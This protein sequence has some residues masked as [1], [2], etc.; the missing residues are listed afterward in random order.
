MDAKEKIVTIAKSLISNYISQTYSDKD[1][2]HEEL[3]RIND[4]FENLDISFKTIQPGMPT[5]AINHGKGKVSLYFDDKDNV[6][7]AELINS[8][9]ILIHEVY[10]S[11]SD[12][13]NL[14]QVVFLEEGYVTLITAET[15]RYAIDNPPQI[16]GVD[17]KELK[18]LLQSQELE[19]GYTIPSEIVRSIQLIMEQYGFDS[20]YEYIFNGIDKLKE[21]ARSIDP[22]LAKI[23]ELQERKTT[24]SATLKFETKY[25]LKAFEEIDFSTLSPT[26]VEMNRLLQTYL[27]KSEEVYR[28]PRIYELVKKFNPALIGYQDFYLQVQ[29][30]TDEEIRNRLQ[31]E[32]PQEPID[33]KLHEDIPQTIKQMLQIAKTYDNSSSPLKPSTFG[34][35][36]FYSIMI[37][38]DLFQKGIQEP[39]KDDIMK[40]NSYIAFNTNAE[41]IVLSTVSHYMSY[42]IT[43]CE[44]G[45]SLNQILNENLTN[46][47]LLTVH[48]RKTNKT[49]LPLEDKIEQTIDSLI[50]QNTGS[51][52]YLYT[53]FC[54]QLPHILEQ[55]FDENHIYNEN[56]YD[57]YVS[58]LKNAFD[59]AQFPEAITQAGHSP[60]MLF[61]QFISSNISITSEHF[62]EQII[63]LLKIINNRNPNLGQA[64]GKLEDL[65]FFISMAYETLQQSG[66][67]ELL[68]EFSENLVIASYNQGSNSKFSQA[69]CQ[70]SRKN[71]IKGIRPNQNIETTLTSIISSPEFYKDLGTIKTMFDTYPKI[72]EKI[73]STQSFRKMLL[74]ELPG[75]LQSKVKDKYFCGIV[76]M[77]TIIN[78]I[79]GTIAPK[80]E[81]FSSEKV[82]Q[83]SPLVQFSVKYYIYQQLVANNNLEGAK[84]LFLDN[85]SVMANDT[86]SVLNYNTVVSMARQ[87]SVQGCQAEAHTAFETLEKNSITNQTETG[88]TK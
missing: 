77:D 57:Y 3:A 60:E 47:M 55:E 65:S 46:S 21:I 78:A 39:S 41:N 35:I 82:T 58:L 75:E 5:R 79:F 87:P 73:F 14:S 86:A 19:N 69:T 76:S 34:S 72:Y 70:E 50:Q 42:V 43:K 48:M 31:S 62:P 10:H 36:N 6:S 63:C 40:Y 28:N 25:F 12:K 67:E 53:L 54:F 52:E 15:I 64:T 83:L 56:D 11:I 4:I 49:E 59:K 23:L 16:D 17:P 88:I 33:Y 51:Q 8:I 38:Y 81:Q 84:K 1:N 37:A 2:I 85:E 45:M 66:N 24:N 80:P 68:K 9:E 22:E 32:L 44:E 71:G 29:D 27:V 61:M 13:P 26:L 74:Q 18:L 7:E 20:K 30:L